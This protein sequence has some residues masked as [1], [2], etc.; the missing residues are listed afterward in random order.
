[1]PTVRLSAQSIMHMYFG[2]VEPPDEPPAQAPP[3]RGQRPP[4]ASQRR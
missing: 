2:D 1:M 4:G 3:E